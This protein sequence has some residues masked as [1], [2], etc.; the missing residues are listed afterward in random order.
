MKILGETVI[1][2]ENVGMEYN[3]NKEKVDNLKEYVIKFLKRELKFTKFWALRGV[4]FEV[5]KGDKLGIIGLNGA[6]KS[7]LLKLISGVIKPTEG[8]IEIKGKIVPLLELGSGFDHEYTGRENIYLKGSLLGYSKKYLDEK[9]DEIIEFSE[10]GDF[11]DIPLKNYSTGMSARLAFSI[12]TVVEPEIMILDEVLAVGDAKFREKSEARMKSL[13]GEDVTVLYVSHTLNSVRQLCNKAIWLENGQ[14]VMK[15]P[16]KEVCDKY[17]E[18]TLSNETVIVTESDPD[19]NEK[20]VPVD[21]KIILTFNENIKAG[22]NWIE[23]VTSSGEIVPIN[24]TIEGNTLTIEP[25]TSLTNGT[26]YYV[27]LHSKSITDLEGNELNA[28]SIFFTTESE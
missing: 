3:L 2:V 12:A 11:I 5:E 26:E 8:T 14:L 21:K 18:W 7:T 6:G 24:K 16:V 9:I 15:G 22:S 28:Y 25:T 17:E 4:S 23:L 1:K 20:N 13:L 19:K 10:L 27:V